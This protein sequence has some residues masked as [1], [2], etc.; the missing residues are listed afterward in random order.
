MFNIL[1][2]D[3][4][5]ARIGVASANSIALIPS[6]LDFI[7]NDENTLHNIIELIDQNQ[8]KL[9]VVGLPQNSQGQDT[10]Q[11]KKVRDFATELKKV[12]NIH[13]EFT[14]ESNTSQLSEKGLEVSGKPFSKGDIDSGS[15][16]II[17]QR[18]FDDNNN[19]LTNI[20][21]ELE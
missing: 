4:G 5:D 17:L 19:N 21:K 3:V 14:D 9:L 6:P 1:G 13:I 12:T 18:F 15:A 10:E 8:T 16:V 2:L 7:I 11:T 20:I